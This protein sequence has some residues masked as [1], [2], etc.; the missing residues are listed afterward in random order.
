M[1]RREASRGEV[2][3]PKLSGALEA[4]PVPPTYREL[5]KLW[6]QGLL[7]CI[8]PQY[9]RPCPLSVCGV[10][11]LFL[12]RAARTVQASGPTTPGPLCPSVSK[13]Q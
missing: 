4:S 13:L 9:E 11:A 6:F 8:L 5:R 1:K 12:R 3:S 7:A 2:L 10:T